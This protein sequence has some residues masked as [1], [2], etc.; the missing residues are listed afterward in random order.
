MGLPCRLVACVNE[1]DVI[2]RWIQTGELKLAPQV[3]K[4]VSPSMD[5]QVPYNV[6]RIIWLASL[7]RV[8]ARLFFNVV[9]YTS[10]TW[11][12]QFDDRFTATFMEEFYSTG[13][14][15][16]PAVV[17]NRLSKC[18]SSA[19]VSEANI[20]LTIRLVK[21]KFKYL[22][23]PHTAIG[24]HSALCQMFDDFRLSIERRLMFKQHTNFFFICSSSGEQHTRTKRAVLATATPVKF[25]E[26]ISKIL[27]ENLVLPTELAALRSNPKFAQ[28]MR[29]GD[30]RV[31]LGPSCLS[32]SS[33]LIKQVVCRTGSA[34]CAKKFLTFTRSSNSAAWL[35]VVAHV[36][37]QQSCELLILCSS[38]DGHSLLP[39]VTTNQ[40]RQRFCDFFFL[41]FSPLRK[42]ASPPRPSNPC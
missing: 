3:A 23:D 29:A 6:E 41:L 30:V 15:S 10:L 19:V 27:N 25:L 21:D 42:H 39:A 26:S 35:N 24:V 1:N 9:S 16:T 7:V 2:H 12:A 17:F 40:G 32:F 20:S 14:A 4:T 18:L 31:V 22:I 8:P 38:W 11:T 28:V 36:V 5:I 33:G 34:C 37:L 13:T